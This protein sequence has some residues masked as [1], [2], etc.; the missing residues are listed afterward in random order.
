MEQV[1][2]EKSRLLFS[3]LT[4]G[5][6]II[7]IVESRSLPFGSI[8]KIESGFFPI[9]FGVII[10]VLSLI[11]IFTASFSLYKN[12]KT[13]TENADTTSGINF[14]GLFIM[15]AIFILFAILSYGI[16]YLFASAVALALAGYFYGLRKWRLLSLVVFTSPTTWFI[17]E[18]LLEVSLPSG[19][20]L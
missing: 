10:I 9:V 12:T 15:I 19:A 16:G 1:P 13:N 14:R 17:F 2:T 18:R 5:L 8:T 20:W 4:L 3:V 11:M 6:G 7:T